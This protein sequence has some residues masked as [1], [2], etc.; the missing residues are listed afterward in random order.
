MGVHKCNI[1]QPD[2]TRSA[3]TE[4]FQVKTLREDPILEWASERFCL[5]A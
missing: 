1:L 5:I 2:K 4:G 3:R